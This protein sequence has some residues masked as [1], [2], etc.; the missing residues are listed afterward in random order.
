MTA[1]LL[2]SIKQVKRLI[3]AIV[4]FT[5]LIIGVAMVVLPGPAFVVIPIGIGILATEFAWANSLFKKIK[6]R[7]QRTNRKEG[8]N[9]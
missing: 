8:G 7:L 4:G 3:V 5:V 6:A 9:G 1:Y 2:K